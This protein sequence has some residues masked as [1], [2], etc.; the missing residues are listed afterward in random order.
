MRRSNNYSCPPT[1]RIIVYYN[2][3]RNRKFAT[4]VSIPDS[5]TLPIQSSVSII[6][7]IFVKRNNS[8][9]NTQ[10][11]IFTANT[12]ICIGPIIE[13][14]TTIYI[15]RCICYYTYSSTSVSVI[16]CN[17]STIKIK[18]TPCKYSYSTTN[19]ILT[20]RTACNF[21]ILEIIKNST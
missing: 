7:F 15:T 8:A 6:N 4:I 20:N 18:L 19:R 12:A 16:L 14:H 2:S 5:T 11:T 3:I 9:V 21:T 1:F 10:I 17:N 13:Y